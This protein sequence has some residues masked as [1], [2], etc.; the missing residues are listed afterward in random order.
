MKNYYNPDIFF[1]LFMER[2]NRYKVW[3]KE[4]S[5]MCYGR[6]L[7]L[8]CSFHVIPSLLSYRLETKGGVS[9]QIPKTYGLRNWTFSLT[10]PYGGAAHK[11]S[12]LVKGWCLIRGSDM[13][14]Q[15][16]QEMKQTKVCIVSSGVNKAVKENWG[17]QGED[18][19]IPMMSFCLLTGKVSSLK[20]QTFTEYGGMMSLVIFLRVICF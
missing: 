19:S 4:V 9:L 12:A 5:R 6:K 8:F 16:C 15:K 1:R 18:Y 11:Q 13:I 17:M 7:H 20:P 14:S 10:L 3:L 2:N